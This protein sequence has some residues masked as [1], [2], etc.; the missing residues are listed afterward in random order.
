MSQV[1]LGTPARQVST[2]P[3]AMKRPLPDWAL[4]LGLAASV[5]VFWELAIRLFGVPT[6]V[7]P[8]PSAVIRFVTWISASR[9]ISDGICF[10]SGFIF[11]TCMRW[12]SPRSV[13]FKRS[14]WTS[15]YHA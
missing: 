7:L 6:F 1:T 15:A 5:T 13:Q 8:A 11:M 14:F 4:A 9:Q 10:L 2:Q 3:E 12:I